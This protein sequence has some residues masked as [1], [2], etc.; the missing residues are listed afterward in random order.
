[1]LDVCRR[2]LLIVAVIHFLAV[3][4][5]SCCLSS[6]SSRRRSRSV[7]TSSST[8]ASFATAGVFLLARDVM[9]KLQFYKTV[10]SVDWRKTSDRFD[11][12]A[13]KSFFGLV[14]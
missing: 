8:A 12:T 7:R 6:K 10:A 3:T 2:Q 4:W 5:L 9:A 11:R 1:M 14:G 13:L